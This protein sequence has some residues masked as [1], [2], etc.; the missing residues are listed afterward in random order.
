MA[1]SCLITTSEYLA[2]RLWPLVVYWWWVVALCGFLMASEWPHQS[3]HTH[4]KVW[5]SIAKSANRPEQF[6]PVVSLSW[7]LWFSKSKQIP[8]GY[9]IHQ[10]CTPAFAEPVMSGTEHRQ[11]PPSHWSHHNRLRTLTPNLGHDVIS[12]FPW[13][14]P[15]RLMFRRGTPR[16][17]G[18]CP[19]RKHHFEPFGASDGTL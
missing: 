8:F 14:W 18:W 9:I 16:K 19:T 4:E 12:P 5:D 17:I 2:F 7:K 13:C 3:S 11:Y 6:Q 1:Y 15:A 10:W